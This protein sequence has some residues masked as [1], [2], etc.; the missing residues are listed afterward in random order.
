MLE[1]VYH[2]PVDEDGNELNDGSLEE[3]PCTCGAE[4]DSECVC[5]R[6]LVH[7]E[8]DPQGKSH[9]WPCEPGMHNKS[10]HPEWDEYWNQVNGW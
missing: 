10:Y 5:N 8:I 6:G 7:V 9:V 1:F 3:Q 4:N 2:Y